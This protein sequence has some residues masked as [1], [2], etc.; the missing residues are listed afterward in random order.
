M[1]FSVPNRPTGTAPRDINAILGDFDA[2]ATDYETGF[3][4]YEDLPFERHGAFTG[5]TTNVFIL[6]YTTISGLMP[7]VQFNQ[8]NP[9]QFEFDPG[10]YVSSGRTAKFRLRCMILTN[11]VAPAANFTI[12]LYPV[13]TIGGASGASPNIATLGGVIGAVTINA[14]AANAMTRGVGAD[15]NAPASGLYAFGYLVNVVTAANCL[16]IVYARLQMHWTNP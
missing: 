2:M 14:P 16:N 15:F 3:S 11:A 5:S 6:G 9:V 4:T 10:D 13:A 12:G 7:N 1:P 8:P